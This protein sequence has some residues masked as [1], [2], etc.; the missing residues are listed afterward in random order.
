MHARLPGTP[1]PIPVPPDLVEVMGYRGAARFVGLYWESAGDEVVVTD[2]RFS[3]TGESFAYL[4]YTRHRAVC[5]HLLPFCLGSSDKRAE[6]YLLLDR[7]ELRASVAPRNEAQG[8]LKDQ[9]PP[10]TVLTPEEIEQIQRA[11]DSML[12]DG[13][14]EVSVD[15]QAIARAMEEQR[16]A[17]VRLIAYCDLWP[18]N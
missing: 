12:I 1:L 16:Q 9:F 14:Q 17:I 18:G 7:H 5:P 2:G 4:T 3:G 15:P 6:Y 8:F 13:W 11:A 10:A